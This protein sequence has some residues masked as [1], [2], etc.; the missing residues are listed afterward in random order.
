PGLTAE[1]FVPSP[2]AAGE[3]L[4][5]TGDL[6][7][8]R[9]DG[10][11]DYL[12]RIDHQVKIRGFRIEPGEIEAA[13]LAHPGIEQAAVVA[14]DDAGD[15]RLVAY[16]VGEAAADAAELRAHLQ[17][18]LPDYMVPAALVALDQLPLTSN[19]KL[20]RNA[21]PAPEAHSRQTY[22]AT[23]NAAEQALAGILAGVL[24]LDRVGIDDNFFALGGDSIQSIQ[25][26]ARAH[27][28]GLKLTARQ[29]FE[30]QTVAGLATVVEAATSP[31]A[32][33]G[34]VQGEA[35]L[36]PIQHW[37]FAQD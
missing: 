5:R 28:A 36:T 8:W 12:G 31:I 1:R 26:V 19:G 21:L 27:R 25:V 13:L 14:R 37:F 33:Q 24:G 16:L 22:L 20:D 17:R 23:R 10:A 34:L 4:Y 35:P 9:P 30:Q 15:R 2:F 3:R 29:I 32:E 6:A 11:L 7:R 18:T